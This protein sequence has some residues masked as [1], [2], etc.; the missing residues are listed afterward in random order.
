MTPPRPKPELAAAEAPERDRKA[1]HI[2]LALEERM[3]VRRDA[4]DRLA[5]EHCALPEID[6]DD[7]DVSCEFLGKRLEA[8]LLVSSM[9]GGTGEAAR[10][11]RHLAEAAELRGIAIAVGSQRKA[12]EDPVTAASFEV[13]RYAPTVPVLGNLGAVQLN[14]GFGVAQC[15]KALDMLGADALILHL[16]PLQEA[17][18]PEGQTRFRSLLPKIAEVVAGL[19][20]PVVVKEIGSGLSERVGREL[21]RVGVRI[22]DTAGVGGTSWARIEAARA[23]DFDI[24]ELFADWGIPTPDSIRALARIPGIQV[25]ASGGIRH[26]LDVAK[27]IALGA[28]LAGMAY[29][30][31]QPARVSAAAVA[32]K[33]D[34]TVRELKIAMFCAGARNLAELRRLPLR[35]VA[36]GSR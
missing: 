6:L 34:R 28:D 9:T 31:L 11:N 29:R 14:Y 30:F 13:R 24:G 15:R 12:I 27:A 25:I 5:F 35:E 1:E 26:G 18:Q 32:E 16:N 20:A 36:E 3:Q 23:D 8:P 19:G 17:I 7:V 22:L 2:A 4:F 21:Q 33:I 10:I